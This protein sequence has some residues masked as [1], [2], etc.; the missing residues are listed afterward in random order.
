MASEDLTICSTAYNE[1]ESVGEALRELR[2]HFPNAEVILVDDGSTDETAAIARKV[3]GVVVISHS[4]NIGYGAGLKTAMRRASRNVVAWFDC[5]GQHRAQ[6]LEKVVGSVLAGA[7]DAVV[8][9]R[10]AGS[11]IL[12]DR[13]PGKWFLKKVAELVARS[14]IPD[15]NSGMRCFRR[16]V[17]LRYL[18]LLPDGF[19]ASSTSTLLMIKRGYRLGYEDIVSCGRKGKS[20][21]RVLRDGWAT[22]TLILRIVILFE[23]FGFFALLSF[24]QIVPGLAYGVTLALTRGLGFPVLAATLVLSGLLTFFMGLVCDQIV[25]LRKE[26]LEELEARF[27]QSGSEVEP[28]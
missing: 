28:K 14:R 13:I 25:S 10:K 2:R 21:V 18:H 19:S 3:K 4:R 7:N 5:D 23:A 8:G 11:D 22:L 27:G 1:A 17:I 20:T 9:A 15:L 12:L 6:D 24:L 16:D 26:R